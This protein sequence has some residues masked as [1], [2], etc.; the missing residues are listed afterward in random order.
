MLTEE[1]EARRRAHDRI[2]TAESEARILKAIE[3]HSE[4]WRHGNGVSCNRHFVAF[5]EQDR[6]ATRLS[7][8]RTGAHVLIRPENRDRRPISWEELM[9]VKTAMGLGDVWMVEIYPPVDPV[10]HVNNVIDARHL[11]VVPE[12]VLPFAWRATSGFPVGLAEDPARALE[13]HQGRPGGGR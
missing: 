13:R 12:S 11:W 6:G 7:V 1:Q 5:V 10:D 9:E 4:E 3:G 2:A 8:Q